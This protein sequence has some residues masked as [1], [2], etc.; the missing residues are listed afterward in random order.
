MMRVLSKEETKAFLMGATGMHLP[1]CEVWDTGRCTCPA[2]ADCDPLVDLPQPL[3]KS[4][5]WR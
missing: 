2:A 3:A 1:N 5:E 4:K